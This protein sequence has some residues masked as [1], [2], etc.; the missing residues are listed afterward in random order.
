MSSPSAGLS[1]KEDTVCDGEHVII[2]NYYR[3]DDYDPNNSIRHLFSYRDTATSSRD[4]SR[5][6]LCCWDNTGLCKGKY[7]TV[8]LLVRG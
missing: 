6:N 3:A 7:E 2:E 1:S 5:C 4:G 8:A